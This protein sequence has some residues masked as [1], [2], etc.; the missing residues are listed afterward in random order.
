[1]KIGQ[2]IGRCLPK[3]IQFKRELAYLAGR[4]NWGYMPQGKLCQ[5]LGVV[6]GSSKPLPTHCQNRYP[7]PNG[8]SDHTRVRPPTPFRV[9]DGQERAGFYPRTIC[10]CETIVVVWETIPCDTSP[11]VAHHVSSGVKTSGV[12][13]CSTHSKSLA[14]LALWQPSRLVRAL[15]SNAHPW[16]LSVVRWPLRFLTQTSLAARLSAALQGQP[17]IRLV[18]AP[19]DL[20]GITRHIKG[21]RSRRFGGLFAFAGAV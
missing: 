5:S 18:F 13:I 1:M 6:E 14:F 4:S 12:T 9:V 3:Q 15:A 8:W 16:V 11:K 17:A 2:L 7:S 21:R 10:K 20:S 19:T